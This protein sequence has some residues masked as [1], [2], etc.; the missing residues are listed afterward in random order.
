MAYQVAK[1]IGAAAAV[2]NGEVDA[3][4]LTGGLAHNPRIVKWILDRVSFIAAIKVYP[5]EDEFEALSEAVSAAIH[6]SEL[7]LEYT[8]TY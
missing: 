2:L 1:E 3:I 4:L 6:G 5:G 7:I 8:K